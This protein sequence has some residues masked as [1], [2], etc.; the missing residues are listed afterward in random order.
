MVSSRRNMQIFLVIIALVLG[1]PVTIIVG[2][3]LYDRFFQTK[4]VLL[5]NFPLIGRGRYLMHRLRPLMRQYFADDNSFTPRIIIDWILN[6]SAGKTGYFSFDKFD[7]TSSLHDGNHQMKHSVTPYNIDE[8]APVYPLVGPQRK[9]PF[10]MHGYFYRSAMSLGSLGFEATSAMAAACCDADVAF[11]TGEGSLSVHHIPRVPFSYQQ[12]F[13]YKKVPKITKLFWW[14]MPGK[15]I[16]NHLVDFLGNWKCSKDLRDLYL[17]SEKEWTFYTI[18]WNASQECF[19]APQ[20]LNEDFGH[21]ILQV[22][23][24]LYG[25]RQKTK[26]GSVKLD[27]DRFRKVSSFCNMIEIKLAQGAKQTGGILKAKKNTPTIA[28]IRGV[29]PNI[30]LISPNR[31]PFLEE[32]KIREFY[33]YLEKISEMS[34]GKP[35][36]FKTV[37]SDESSIEPFVKVLAELPKGKGPD[38]ITID[39]GDGGTGAAPIAL[40]ILFGKKIYEALDIV[41]R[42]LREYGVRDRVKIFAASKLYAPH[43]S[44]R[45]MALGADAI[46][47]ARSIMIAGG[48]I[49][50][51]ICSGEE[52]DCPVGLATMNKGKRRA[53]AQTWD[54]KVEQIQN[55]I[56]AHN[57]GLVQVAAV[58]GVKS[59]HLLERKHIVSPTRIRMET[60]LGVA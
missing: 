42:V 5:G 14:M 1:I 54:K 30:D 50:A 44:A 4:N 20:D 56:K 27:W 33:E 45:A 26:D 32:G 19:P 59:P 35:V 13:T 18:D 31:F 53:Y 23:S 16:K 11:N 10:Q 17:F 29:H 12:F 6:V 15:R 2:I 40:G 25:L 3:A 58:C 39:G 37:I 47:N 46:G 60:A 36:G 49:R 9:H 22:S 43:M 55:Y 7:T 8:M 21:I 52:G 38:F 57:K 28:E 34:G 51:G 24:S 41:D 48:C